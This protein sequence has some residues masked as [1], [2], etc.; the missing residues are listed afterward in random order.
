MELGYRLVEA[1][2]LGQLAITVL[3]E[4]V[5]LGG[6]GEQ[7][8]HAHNVTMIEVIGNGQLLVDLHAQVVVLL[9][10]V[11]PYDLARVPLQCLLVNEFAHRAELAPAQQ[12][13][14]DVVLDLLVLGRFHLVHLVLG[15]E[16]HERVRIEI[17]QRYAVC[18]RCVFV[19]SIDED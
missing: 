3:H 6:G 8:V 2:E 7:I 11:P 16:H 9:E 15:A 13:P 14:F 4:H 18:I 10:H 19:C 12:F 5:H 17:G 1:D